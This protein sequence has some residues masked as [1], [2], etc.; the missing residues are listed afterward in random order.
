LFSHKI[1][2]NGHSF[3]VDIWSL[4]VIAYALAVGRPP[5]ETSDVK[6]TYTKIKNCNYSYPDDAYV[7][8]YCKSLISKMLQRDPRH[9]ATVE[10]LLNDE[11]FT[12]APFP[13]SLPMST[14]ACPPNSNFMKQYLPPSLTKR[15]SG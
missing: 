8:E 14:L 10:E 4:G 11:F 15:I 12:S 5:F 3:E 6:T 1:D 9:R 13:L 7:S 2:I